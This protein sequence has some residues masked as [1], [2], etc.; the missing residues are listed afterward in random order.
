M[1]DT[2]ASDPIS[3]AGFAINGFEPMD[4]VTE[5]IDGWLVKCLPGCFI[6]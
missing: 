3:V 6:R 1:L 5:G 2:T 4:S